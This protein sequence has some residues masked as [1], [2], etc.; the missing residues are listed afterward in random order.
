MKKFE[1]GYTNR[2]LLI[3]APRLWP[4]L[5]PLGLACLK[6]FA[7]SN[8]ILCDVIDL[9]IYFFNLMPPHIKRLWEIPVY[10]AMSDKLWGFINLNFRDD[11]KRIT[12]IIVNHP[13]EHIGFSIW[14]SNKKFTQK[15]IQHLK[16]IEPNKKII[17]GGPEITLSY[18]VKKNI[19]IKNIFSADYLIA[20]E[21]ESPLLKI[22][23]NNK[24]KNVNIFD[25][26]ELKNLDET[27]QADFSQ[28]IRTDYRYPSVYPVWMT[29]GC[30]R[31][32]AFCV[33]HT[34]YRK[35][36]SKNPVTTANE[37]S[38]YYDNQ[39]IAHFIFFD[40]L[41]N[42]NLNLFEKFLDE[43]IKINKPIKW[44]AQ[45]LIRNDMPDKLFHKM[46]KSGCYN[47]F[48]GL[49]SG[50]DR[51]LKAM[52]KG[53]TAKDAVSFFKKC[54]KADLHFEISMIAGFPGETNED[55]LETK[56]FIESNACLIPKIAQINPYMNLAGS[57]LNKSI[58]KNEVEPVNL[59]EIKKRI[60]QL[61]AIF[62][63]NNIKYTSS[64][65]NNLIA[66]EADFD[67]KL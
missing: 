6:A 29:R 24:D 62:D 54:K 41:L 32:C 34:L 19:I 13:A 63:N 8:A 45:V 14:H 44:E 12:E 15:F 28:I 21:G 38:N 39:K 25:Y 43:L 11:L 4:R 26:D 48:V 30:V 16:K 60:D 10:P 64:Y 35:F 66:L 20:G 51:I 27:P 67:I 61:V 50:C 22:L 57:P 46:K 53:F 36:R 33:E 49:E 40:S 5:A 65:I 56:R 31:H 7:Q 9:N 52:D 42:G 47:I 17:V 23:T 37:L 59:T 18:N 58:G 1:T 3:T 2:I 55:F